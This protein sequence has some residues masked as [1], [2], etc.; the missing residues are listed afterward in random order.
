MHPWQNVVALGDSFTEGVGEA[1]ADLPLQG[2]FDIIATAL[3]HDNPS[4]H[5][6]NLARRGLTAQQVRETQLEAALALT[7]D[8]ASVIAG[9]NDAL[10]GQWQAEVYERELQTMIATLKGAGATLFMS[11]WPNWAVRL[12]LSEGHRA[13]LTAQL[14]EGNAITTRLAREF[15]AILLDV[16]ASPINHDTRF[17]SV[18]RI[19]PNAA[20]YRAYALEALNATERQTGYAL[21]KPG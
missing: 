1:T 4:L 19:H 10:K 14:E 18:D 11:T 16:W 12:P 9:A 2:S 5:Y 3:R 17:W 6:T 8:F 20:G 13:Q 15:D 7:P 21:A